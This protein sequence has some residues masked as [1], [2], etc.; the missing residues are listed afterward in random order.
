LQFQ[1]QASA[2]LQPSLGVMRQGL[3]ETCIYQVQ[4]LEERGKLSD[5]AVAFLAC[6]RRADALRCYEAAGDVHMAFALLLRSAPAPPPAA[7]R[8]LAASLIDTLQQSGRHSE[9]GDVAATYLK[10]AVAAARCYAAGGHW[11]SALAVVS[12][13][14]DAQLLTTVVAPAAAA[15]AEAQLAD[16]RGDA[17][18][19]GKYMERL[20]QLREKRTMMAAALGALPCLFSKSPLPLVFTL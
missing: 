15:A 19:V 10:D 8:R 11:R 14:N 12:Q 13:A 4:S 2:T 18:R 7:I 16:A 5:A 17:A 9:A 3:P 6:R 1:V 20:R